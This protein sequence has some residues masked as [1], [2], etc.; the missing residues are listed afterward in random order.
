MICSAC[1][2]RVP[3]LET[4]KIVGQI[5]KGVVLH[6]YMFPHRATDSHGQNEVGME[7]QGIR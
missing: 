1:G 3:D 7:N 2:G 4:S 6:F 5:K